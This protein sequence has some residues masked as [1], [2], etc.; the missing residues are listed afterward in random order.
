MDCRGK[1]GL[2][3]L[4]SVP[5]NPG[6]RQ[7]FDLIKILEM[8]ECFYTWLWTE[9]FPFWIS[10]HPG[11][12]VNSLK[13]LPHFTI[14]ISNFPSQCKQQAVDR[15]GK[16]R[17]KSNMDVRQKCVCCSFFGENFGNLLMFS[18]F[19]F[20]TDFRIKSVIN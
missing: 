19:S 2:D 6:T 17:S 5:L 11:F 4:T 15:D 9:T 12:L 20:C 8:K 16:F 18:S 10:C 3:S 7:H 13:F 1:R 14:F